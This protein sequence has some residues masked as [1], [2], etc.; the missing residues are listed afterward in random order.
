MARSILTIVLAAGEGT[1][2]RSAT[3]KILH[4]I[5]NLP[6]VCHVLNTVSSLKNND[7]CVVLGNQSALVEETIKKFIKNDNMFENINI[8]FCEQKERLGTAH[9]I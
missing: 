7:I 5:A 1:R 6:M 4:K 9:A 2:M 3:P 8:A